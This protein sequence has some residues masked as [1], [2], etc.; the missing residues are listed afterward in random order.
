LATASDPT[1][2]VSLVPATPADV[3]TLLAW[4][5]DFYAHEGIPFD[6]AAS[7]A[8]DRRQGRVANLLLGLVE[9]AG[10]EPATS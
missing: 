7:A 10:I 6:P 4:M 9:L 5:Q 3:P 1:R 8:V 2:T